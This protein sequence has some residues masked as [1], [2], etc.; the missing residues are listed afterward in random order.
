MEKND[1]VTVTAE[2]VGTQCEGIARLGGVTL[3]V[4]YLLRG[5]VPS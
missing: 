5:S 3:F 4:P 1:I 2:A